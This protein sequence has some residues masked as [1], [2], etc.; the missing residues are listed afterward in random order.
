M[1]RVG[2]GQDLL[3]MGKTST[4]SLCDEQQMLVLCQQIPSPRIM[5]ECP[6]NAMVR[7]ICICFSPIALIPWVLTIMRAERCFLLLIAPRWPRQHWF[8]ELLLLSETKPIRLSSTPSLLTRNNGQIS[9]P[10]PASLQLHAWL[11]N[12]MSSGM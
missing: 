6:F 10:E 3:T 5:G 2:A 9:H 8:S 12:S 1:P 11:L 4:G 7:D